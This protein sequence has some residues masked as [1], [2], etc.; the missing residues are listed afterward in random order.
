MNARKMRKLNRMKEDLVFEILIDIAALIF[1]AMVAWV[2]CT[3]S[4]FV[5][6]GILGVGL[7]FTC[8]CIYISY[9]E[10]RERKEILMG[11]EG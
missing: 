4:K 9:E 1:V 2:C 6:G 5:G 10:Y 11:D 7:T 3:V 8:Y